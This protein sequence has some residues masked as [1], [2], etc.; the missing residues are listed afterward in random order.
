ME[1][2]EMKKIW[3]AQNH[4]LLY[5][6]NETALHNRVLSKKKKAHHITNFSELFIMIVY[7]ISGSLIFWVNYSKPVGNISLY[8]LTAWMYGSVLYVL[9]S[10][11]RRI[12]GDSHF[13][14]SLRGDLD[15]AVSVAAYQVRLSQISLWSVLPMGILLLLGVWEGGKSIWVAGLVL[16][17]FGLSYYAG[18]WEHGLYKARKRELEILKDKLENEGLNADHSS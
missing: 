8:L 7:T 12:N 16:I 2:D 4:E 11:F 14:R 9:I 5:A 10:R 15:H 3:D 13:D 1:F 6:I 18:T 17:S